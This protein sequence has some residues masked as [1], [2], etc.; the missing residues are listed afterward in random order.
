MSPSGNVW[1]E[2]AV[3]SVTNLELTPPTIQTQPKSMSLKA[4]EASTLRVEALTSEPNTK[5]TYQWY[6]NT[7]NSNVGGKA[8]LG[9]TSDNYTP[10]LAQGTTYYY[11]AVRC[12][13]GTDISVATKSVCAA[14]TYEGVVGA[15]T[16]S[17]AT[18]ESSAT[19]APWVTEEV[20]TTQ[21]TLPTV[22][23]APARSN[24]LLVIVVAVIVVIA[25]LGIIATV[26]ILKFYG[27]RDDYEEPEEPRP[28]RRSRP[29]PE[30]QHQPESQRRTEPRWQPDPEPELPNDDEWDDLSDLGDLSLYFGDDDDLK[31]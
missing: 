25:V 17:S 14:V 30:P 27:G 23:A 9:A 13:N 10:D 11:C 5:L 4:G 3:I 16:P 18:A 1:S 24:T 6:K 28:A 26:L 19:L 8:I 15:T 29:Q 21:E 31:F 20:P 7:I 12:T 2:A 22:T